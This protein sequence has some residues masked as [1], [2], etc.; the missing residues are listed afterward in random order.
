MESIQKLVLL[1][2]VLMKKVCRHKI[3]KTSGVFSIHHCLHRSDVFIH[4]KWGTLEKLW[5]F[6]LASTFGL[7]TSRTI[8]REVWLHILI[9]T[10]VIHTYWKFWWT[11]PLMPCIRFHVL[12]VFFWTS[13]HMLV[14]LEHWV[15]AAIRFLKGSRTLNLK[16]RGNTQ[17]I[18]LYSWIAH[19]LD[20]GTLLE[21]R[22]N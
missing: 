5:P 12:S 9:N 16:I 15:F 4:K 7:L 1:T 20:I 2:Y 21:R 18:H 14:W 17:Y 3:T 10:I 13:T 6:S 8:Y 22:H 19:Q 11:I